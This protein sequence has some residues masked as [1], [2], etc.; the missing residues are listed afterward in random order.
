MGLVVEG[1]VSCGSWGL[2]FRVLDLEL[3]GLGA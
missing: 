1:G 2:R 3:I